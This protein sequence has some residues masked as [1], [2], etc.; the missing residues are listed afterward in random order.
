[1]YLNTN[2]SALDTIQALSNTMTQEN[3]VIQELATGNRI[4]SAASDPAGLAISQLMQSQ[5]SGL[6]QASQ[7]AQNAVSLL[8]TADGALA[9]IDS[10]LQSMR[11][12]AS[13]AATG[14][15]NPAD[16][17]DLQKEMDQYAQEITNI[18][19]TTQF[20]NINLL[21]GGFQNQA[22]QIGANEGQALTLSI[23]PMDAVSLQVAGF[24]ATVSTNTAYINPT[25]LTL[26]SGLQNG[27]QYNVA[28]MKE[29]QAYFSGA[30]GSSELVTSGVTGTYN[31]AGTTTYTLTINSVSASTAYYTITGSDGFSTTGTFALSSQTIASA[32]TLTFT[33]T[34][35]NS[36][37][38]YSLAASSTTV[39]AGDS[40]SVQLN[41]A[42]AS[43]QLFAGA[44]TTGTAIGSLVTVSGYQ[45][46]SG[47]II[48]G[49]TTSGQSANGQV[50][51]F[52]LSSI[53]YSGASALTSVGTQA[54]PATGIAYNGAGPF[55]LVFQVGQNGQA[56]SPAPNGTLSPANYAYVGSGLNITTQASAAE[57]LNIIDQ[58]IQNVN[59]QRA[60]IGANI[61]RLTFAQNNAN[62]EA[63]NLQQANAGYLDANMPLVTAQFMQQ[64]VL[65]QADVGVLAQADQLPAALLKLLP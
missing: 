50:V 62:T 28:V 19:N 1:M 13:E 26:G 15:N 22:V 37:L 2:M 38:S 36:T 5:I 51:S 65:V 63:T 52:S 6:N 57:A 21:A 44:A 59:N 24:S 42:Q 40:A 53:V 43:F 10:I 47:T 11:A 23:G 3:N 16:L 46:L 56:A 49:N 55:Q 41:P 31:G 29:S 33:D 60:N 35:S 32:T 64:Q 39:N 58:A 4:T 30:T 48:V 14:T 34:V 20:N 8:Q 12:L 9:N 18:A 17:Q 61:N 45:Q 27:S 7:N 54:T 25:T